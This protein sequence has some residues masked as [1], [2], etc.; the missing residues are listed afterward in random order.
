MDGQIER[1]RLARRGTP[2]SGCAGHV[3]ASEPWLI[4]WSQSG[5]MDGWNLERRP[6]RN[7]PHPPTCNRRLMEW[8]STTTD[9]DFLADVN[10]PPLRG[11]L[12]DKKLPGLGRTFQAPMIDFPSL[13]G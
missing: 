6:G 11:H 13:N 2:V 4:S 12:L 8:R 5:E 9:V 1:E 7:S 10:A 3:A